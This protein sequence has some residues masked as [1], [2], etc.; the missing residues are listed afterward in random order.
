MRKYDEL[1]FEEGTTPLPK[2]MLKA[3]FAQILI[4]NK[5]TYGEFIE[6]HR[7]YMLAEGKDSREIVSNRNNLIRAMREK[8]DIT[9]RMVDRIVRRILGLNPISLS[10]TVRDRSNTTK[11]Y[12]VDQVFY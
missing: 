11:T 2:D 8:D 7:N 9:F 3:L 6:K 4:E 1:I 5:V 10:M 12:H